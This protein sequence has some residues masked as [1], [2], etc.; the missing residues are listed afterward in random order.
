MTKKLKIAIYTI[1]KNEAKNVKRWADSNEEA[2]VRLVCDTGSTD[3]TQEELKKYGVSVYDINVIPWRFDV[4]RGTSLNLLPHDVDVCIWQDLDE[5]LLP[6]WR[7][8][9]EEKWE[10]GATTGNHR[11]R[12]NGGIWQWHYKIHARHNC[13][14][15]WPVHERLEWTV[16]IKEVWIPEF[17]LDEQQD[18]KPGRSSYLDLLELKIKEGD[19]YWKTY[20]FLAGDYQGIGEIEKAIEARK[21]SY[22]LCDDGGMVKSYIARAI[23]S[24]YAFRKEWDQADNWFQKGVIDSP[25]RETLYRW[26]RSY[27]EREDWDNCYVTTKRCLAVNQKRDGYTLDPEAWGYMVYDTAALASYNVGFYDKAVEFGEQALAL[28][29]EDQR[30][31]NNLD[32]Y[33]EKTK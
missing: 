15:K 9:I 23:A 30:L 4:A 32:F 14:W 3:G 12:H 7:Q 5:A 28:N 10:E 21:T 19:K 29:P 27:F 8:A 26:A 2:D 11:Y 13:N 20:A 16:P 24:I 6:G 18:V 22:D 25:E 33:K 31:K 17:Y 1:C